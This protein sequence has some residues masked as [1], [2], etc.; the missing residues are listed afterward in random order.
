VEGRQHSG[1]PILSLPYFL[2]IKTGEGRARKKE[3]DKEKEERSIIGIKRREPREKKGK[4]EEET[5]KQKK[6]GKKQ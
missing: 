5:K 6:Q 4:T 3:R 1:R 2:P